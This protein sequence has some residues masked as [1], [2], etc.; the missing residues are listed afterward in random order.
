[1]LSIVRGYY[2]HLWRMRRNNIL[3]MCAWSGH[4]PCM[5][6]LGL[7]LGWLIRNGLLGFTSRRYCNGVALVASIV[8]RSPVCFI[9]LPSFDAAAGGLGS[10]ADTK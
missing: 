2:K 3:V 9:A 4:I 1:M 6:E 10:V 8:A 7:C 5:D